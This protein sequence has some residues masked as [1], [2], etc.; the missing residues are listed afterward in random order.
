MDKHTLFG[1]LLILAIVF[2]YSAYNNAKV[3]KAKQQQM[4]EYAEQMAQVQ[5]KDSAT[6]TITM[7]SIGGQTD[8]CFSPSAATIADSLNNP[9]AAGN[10]HIVETNLARYTFSA[11]GGFLKKIEFKDI[12]SYTPKDS[13]KKNLILFDGTDNYVNIDLTLKDHKIVKTKDLH[14]VSSLDDTLIITEDGEQLSLRA[15]P[16]KNVAN[17]AGENISAVDSSSYIEYL[18][19][20]NPDDFRFGFKVNFVNMAN[21]LYANSN[22]Y[23]I[24]WISHMNSVEKNYEYE[25][26]ITTI[27]YMDN[28]DEVDNLEERKNDS[29]EFTSQLKWIGFKQQFFTSVLIADS[30]NFDS[31][32]LEV[33]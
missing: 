14:F 8:N 5:E 28:T 17:A 26:D 24:D 20:F 2:G 30:H 11:M 12:Y 27:Y 25:R 29:K 13:A 15:Y 18:Y 32:N 1:L 3:Q 9:I 19:T 33:V 16:M 31:G 23:S 6:V 7:D 21:Y 4:E 22:S 10:D